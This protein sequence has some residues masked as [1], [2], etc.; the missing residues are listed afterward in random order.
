MLAVSAVLVAAVTVLLIEGSLVYYRL[1]AAP[2][3]L[4]RRKDIQATI[5]CTMSVGLIAALFMMGQ[6]LDNLRDQPFSIPDAVLAGVVAIAFVLAF[7][8]LRKVAPRVTGTTTEAG[9]APSTADKVRR[10]A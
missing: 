10:A 9:A 7:R 3:W 2:A 6:Y 8:W 1:P 4:R 5:S